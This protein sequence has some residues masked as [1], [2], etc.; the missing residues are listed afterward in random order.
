MVSRPRIG[1]LGGGFSGLY[2]ILYLRKFFPSEIDITLF[3]K[4]NY[5]L[6]TP[7]LHEMATGTINA[8][9]TVIP[10]R[11]ALNPRKIKIRC[12]EVREVDLVKRALVTSS[13]EFEFDYLML[14]PGSETN[15]Y[16]F[17]N[18]T[19]NVITFKTIEDAI[20]LRNAPTGALER[21]AWEKDEEKKRNRLTFIVAGGGCT[22]VELV[23]EIAQFI[24]IILRRDYPEIKRSEV[25]LFL[26]EATERILSSFPRYLSEIAQ[27]R[28]KRMG[29]EIL[30]NAPIQR[31]DQDYIYLKEDKIPKGL[32]VWAAGVK[33]RSLPLRP[34]QNRDMNNRIRVNEYLEIPGYNG[35]YMIG[36]GALVINN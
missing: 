12:E 16:C 22:G 5:F 6:Y 31:V 34:E 13:E 18:L 20:R 25:R 24:N 26:I 29:I 8:R 21:A 15:F 28:L 36:D 33:A 30:L 10:I 1:V 32:M 3:D 23:A 11:K 14:A 35:V 2:T 27:E 7:F 19:E 9:H 17:P 4:N